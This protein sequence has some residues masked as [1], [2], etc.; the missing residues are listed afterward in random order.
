MKYHTMQVRCAECLCAPEECVSKDSL[1]CPNCVKD[2]CCCGNIHDAHMKQR[3]S[4]MQFLFQA[5]RM[6][7]AALGLEILCI[8]AAEIGENSGLYLFG[9]N[10]LGIAI[11]YSMG[12]GLAAFTTFLTILGR[13]NYEHME[14]ID[15][16]CSVLE[17]TA[18]KGLITNLKITFSSF[19]LGIK[20]IPSFYRQ[21][22]KRFI[23]KTSIYI[24][25]TA[26]SACILTAETVDLLLYQYSIFLAVPLALL[27]GA[28]TVVATEAYRKM[29]L[30]SNVVKS[31]SRI[32]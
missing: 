2:V 20:K 32:T 13:Y 24:L 17:Q 9:F 19:T 16:C 18:D 6:Y 25:I 30:D 4:L 15:A 26:E 7:A 8:M 14:R 31:Q 22:N 29:K 1:K 23:L 28:F 3:S 21:P 27:V 12:Y 5:K 10:P 11:A